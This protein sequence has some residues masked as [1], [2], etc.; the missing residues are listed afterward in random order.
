MH[1]GLDLHRFRPND[2]YVREHTRAARLE[3][4]RVGV[5]AGVCVQVRGEL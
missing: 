4:C 5:R 2:A 1:M 3:L